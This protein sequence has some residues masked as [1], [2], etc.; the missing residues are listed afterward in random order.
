MILRSGEWP[1]LEQIASAY[2]AYGSEVSLIP[3]AS[4]KILDLSLLFSAPACLLL[5]AE[6]DLM[7]PTE[8]A[9]LQH[10]LVLLPHKNLKVES[11]GILLGTLI[12]RQVA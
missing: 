2:R 11:L 10:S 3:R 8:L 5:T 4:L 6:I 12:I 1:Q 9:V 7:S